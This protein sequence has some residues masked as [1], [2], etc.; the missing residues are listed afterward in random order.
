MLECVFRCIL[1][2]YVSARIQDLFRN[3]TKLTSAD[4]FFVLK[5][6]STDI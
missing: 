5:H 4:F 1:H 2:L 3:K 6:N